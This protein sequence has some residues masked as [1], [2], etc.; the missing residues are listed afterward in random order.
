LRRRRPS[1]DLDQTLAALRHAEWW[2]VLLG[3]LAA[4]AQAHQ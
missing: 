2:Q 1:I 4:R 3:S